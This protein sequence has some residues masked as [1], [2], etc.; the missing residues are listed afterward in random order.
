MLRGR[1]RRGNRW[2]FGVLSACLACGQPRPPAAGIVFELERVDLPRGLT[3]RLAGPLTRDDL[4]AI[5]RTAR[6]EARRAFASF[7]IDITDSQ[8]A[9]WR[10]RVME[11]VA[12]QS[13][14]LA[15]VGES[16]ALGPLGGAGFVDLAA[17]A[18]AA[19]RYAP[20][21]ATRP[22]IIDAIGRGVGRVAVHE[23]GH[24]ILGPTS[25]HNDFDDHSYE[26]G[27]P[28]RA[29]QYYSELYWTTWKPLLERKLGRR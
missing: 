19:I 14:A 11:N 24:Q 20:A 10:I 27:T 23:L 13:H 15:G 17:V 5:E 25:A 22:E 8:T 21:T 6:D 7:R 29:A 4:A 28:E 18:F 9:F 3:A 2:I 12:P 26:N 1:R 16:V